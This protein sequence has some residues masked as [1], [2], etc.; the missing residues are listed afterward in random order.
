MIF[1]YPAFLWAL[2]A[3]SIPVAI[4]LFNFRR[5]KKVYFT[6]VR[7]L[8]ELQEESKSRSRLKE[9]LVLLARCLAIACL[10]LAF[11]QPFIPEEK[12]GPQTSSHAISIYL[13]NSFSMQNVGR[14]GALIDLAKI[15]AKEIVNAYSN[16]D[17]F[18]IITNDF[19]GRHQRFH[20]KE[21]ALNLIEEVK[22]SPSVRP[23]SAV[24][25]RQYDFL[26]TAQEEGKRAYELSDAQKSTFDLENIKEDSL[27]KT[28]FIPLHANQVNNVYIDSCW[29]ETPLQQKGFIQKLHARVVNSGQ[30]ALEVG[31]AKLI[32]NKQ[33]V[34][35]SSFSI[36]PGAEKEIH[37]TFECKQDGFNFGSVKIED[38]PI[39]FDDEL[40]FAFNARVNVAVAIVNGKDVMA[41]NPFSALLMRD[42]LF[43]LQSFSENLIDYG[44]IKRADV[45]ILNQLKEISSGLLSELIKFSEKGGA[46][47]VVPPEK[48]NFPSYNQTLLALKL[49][50][51]GPEDSTD[52][53][54]DKLNLASG[55]F[56]GVFEKVDERINLPVVK[57]HYRFKTQVKRDF[58]Q[59]FSLQ[60]G[61]VFALYSKLN[62][63]KVY[64]FANTLSE[65]TTNFSKHAL[66]VP[67]F[68][69]ISLTSLSA[70]LLSYEAGSN[71]LINL[72]SDV[73]YMDKPPHIKSTDG[74]LDI[75]PELR[76]A[77]SGI[78]LFTRQQINTPGFYRVVAQ[79]KEL[80]PLA[81]N[82]SRTESSLVC[83]DAKELEDL[84]SGKGLRHTSVL[85]GSEEGVSKQI[86]L[87]TEG[88]KLWKLFLLL[89]LLFLLT[90][91]AILR[92]F[93]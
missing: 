30:A 2:T 9:L 40:N 63:A 54:V 48:L 45:L 88:K 22:V 34:A 38:Y 89:T 26:A 80:L 31:S 56:E 55:F 57:R 42:S 21:D 82:Y 13:D 37:F 61:D 20:T 23:L 62:N 86:A 93:K 29:F 3:I 32:L 8:K 6:N 51:L 16:S 18:Q 7:F 81:F 59:L 64:L 83:Y 15:R 91:T 24:L 71:V 36:E 69:R 5:Y 60:N 67:T 79:D 73:S 66:F 90:E 44:A 76:I 50:E 19:E 1:A 12:Q 11:S 17:R 65:P 68:Y 58:D 4:H 84:T 10:V 35:L 46:I 52:T 77:N 85:T 75:I 41:N 25:K 43:K 27:V 28:V 72:K 14:Q 70:S 49:P 47:V 53:K 39:T 87:G 92:F 74:D 33:Q 78:T